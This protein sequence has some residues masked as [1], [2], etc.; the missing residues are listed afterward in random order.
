V[1]TRERFECVSAVLKEYLFLVFGKSSKLMKKYD[2]TTPTTLNHS[3]QF[4][5][6]VT[7]EKK[8]EDMSAT[9][10]PPPPSQKI[11]LPQIITSNIRRE[12][13]LSFTPTDTSKY[14]HSQS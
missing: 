5:T 12:F 8:E 9:L 6:T 14:E 3:E 4:I 1:L 7:S 13:H 11:E 2:V 10:P